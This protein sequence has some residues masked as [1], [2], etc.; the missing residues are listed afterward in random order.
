LL[1]KNLHDS[2]IYTLIPDY[3]AKTD[4]EGNFLISNLAPGKYRLFSLEDA[5]NDLRYNE[6]AERVAF[7]DSLIIPGAEFHQEADTL[8][9]GVDSL[10][11]EGHTHFYPG[12]IYL[13][14]FTEEIFEQYLKTSKRETRNK[15][16]FVFNEPVTDTFELRTLDF[17]MPDWYILEHNEKYDS[18]T[19][20]I[21]DTV[22]AKKDTIPM[23]LSYSQLDSLNQFYIKKDTLEL[24]FSEDLPEESRRGRRGREKDTEEEDAESIPQF[25]WESNISSSP[26]DL[27]KDIILTSPQPLKHVELSGLL[28]Y[29]AEDSLKSPLDFILVPDSLAW[30]TYKLSFPW[31]SDTRYTLEIDSAASENIYGMTSRALNR[32]FTTRE[33][34]YYGAI[35]L[36]L[37]EVSSQVL[38]QL[39]ENTTEE[40]VVEQKIINEEQTVIFNYIPPA[41]YKLKII[42][43]YNENGEWDTGSFQDKYQPERVAYSDEVIRIRSNW[44]NNIS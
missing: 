37:K 18:L 38:V 5:N 42:Y 34:D 10:L 22:L 23:E 1:H 15:C 30:R 4:E 25:T 2:A 8:A 7:A 27:N 29:L 9:R 40:K 17:D 6:G 11:I 41:K 24:V 28:L 39:L 43:D 21:A 3:I 14:Q 35:N 19:V 33:E 20:W 26:F 32:T 31:E 12:P 36:E 16:T 44:E 13:R